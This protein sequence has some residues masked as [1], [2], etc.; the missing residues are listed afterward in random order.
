MNWANFSVRGLSVLP[1]LA[2]LASAALTSGCDDPLTRLDLVVSTRSVGARVEVDADP[3]RAAP[4]P[5][6]SATVRFWMASPEPEPV[7]GW[8]LAICVAAES[9][10]GAP[11]CAEP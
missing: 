9:R 7:L 10:S 8:S 6:E 3:E 5:G 11:I 1:A 2:G 4:A